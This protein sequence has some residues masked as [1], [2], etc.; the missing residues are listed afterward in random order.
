MYKQATIIN[1]WYHVNAWLQYYE[2]Y[3]LETGADLVLHVQPL[4]LTCMHEQFLVITRMTPVL[5][6]QQQRP[7]SETTGSCTILAE[8]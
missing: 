1:E 3:V 8:E 6:K 5:K 7:H 4:F 2:I